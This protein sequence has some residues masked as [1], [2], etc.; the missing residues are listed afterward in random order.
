[1]ASVAALLAVSAT[2]SGGDLLGVPE[3][4]LAAEALVPSTI[5][6][7]ELIR[8]YGRLAGKQCFGKEVPQAAGAS[9]QLTLDGA[10]RAL[11]LG[12]GTRALSEDAFIAR[13]GEM[14]F[15]W[16][17]KPW[18]TARSVSNQKTATMN[19]SAETAVYMRELEQRA[20]YDKRNPTGPL[21]TSLRPTL[22]AQM[23]LEP[24]DPTAARVCYRALAGGGGQLTAE[25]LARAFRSILAEEEGDALDYYSFQALVGQSARVVWPP[26]E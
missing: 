12:G 6:V 9:C 14:H 24:V 11:G 3:S 21:P 1:M 17:L 2:A 18:G 10:T 15:A 16:P 7:V 26:A 19:K 22:D 25:G 13:L 8:I 4:A 5:P 23:Q 20:L